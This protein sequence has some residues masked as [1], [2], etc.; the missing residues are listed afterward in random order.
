MGRS[1]YGEADLYIQ[2]YTREFGMISA[3]GKSA[4]KSKRRY[5][6]GLDLFCH[7]EISL[8]GDLK[9]TPYLVELRVLNAFLGI[10]ESLNKLLVAG[11]LTQ[12]IRKG[13]NVHATQP[14]VYTLLG[15]SLSLIDKEK[16]EQRLATLELAF[17]VKLLGLMGIRPDFTRCQKCSSPIT[18]SAR[19]DLE[20][21]GLICQQCVPMPDHDALWLPFSEVQSLMAAFQLRYG[22]WDQCNNIPSAA[23]LGRLMSQFGSFHTNTKLP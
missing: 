23:R 14:A 1:L 19:L 22:Q 10:R 17:K 5:V 15:Q 20:A 11:T 13:V 6:G 8:R 21:G 12:W 4:R 18:E 16:D 2:F 7:S 9:G 3:L